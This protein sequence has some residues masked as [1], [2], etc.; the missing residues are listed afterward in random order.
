[1][2]TQPHSTLIGHTRLELIHDD[3]VLQDTEAIVNA[4]NSELAGGGGVDGAI[5]RAAGPELVRASLALAPCPPGQAVITRGFKLPAAYV[6]HTVGPIWHGGQHGEAETLAAAYRNSLQLAVD[7]RL[8]SLA[9]PSISTGAYGYPVAA[10][11]QVA[12][13]TVRT[14]LSA[15]PPL[16][17]VRFVLFSAGDLNTYRTALV[18]LLQSSLSST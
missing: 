8:R 12:L 17:L 10:A 7:H 1:M 3:I 5:N 6:I 9:F 4:A 14:F 13:H 16:D 15:H 2:P 11:A 18:S